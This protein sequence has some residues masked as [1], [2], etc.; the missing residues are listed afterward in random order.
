MRTHNSTKNQKNTKTHPQ[1]PS[2]IW[3][4]RRVKSRLFACINL[5]SRL[6]NNQRQ[7]APTVMS[8]HVEGLNRDPHSS[9]TP[10]RIRGQGKPGQVHRRLRRQPQPGE[11]RLQTCTPTEVGRPSYDPSD[12]LKLYVYGYL[13]QVRSSRKLERECHRNVEVMWLMKKL[14]P[15]FKTI[16][17]FRKDNIDCVKGVFK[18]FVK[19]CMSLDLYGAKCIAV[20]GTK[21]K[22]VNS[23]DSNFNRKNLA[24]RMKMIDE[25]VS[26]YLGEIEEEDRKEEQA[27]SKHADM[28]QEKVQKLMKRKEEYSELLCKLKESKQNEVSLVDPDC[29]LMK[30][31]GRI[32]PCYNGQVAVDDKNHL[33]VDYNVTNAPADNCQLSS[34]LK[35]RKRCLEQK[36]WM[37]LLTR[38]T[39]VLSKSKTALTT[40]LLLMCLSRTGM[41]L[42]LSRGRVFLRVE[43]SM[44]ISSFMIWERIRL[45]V[46]RAKGLFSYLDH[47]HQK[48]IR[49]YRT[50]ACFS[51]EFFMTKCTLIS[52]GG[53]CGVGSMLKCWMR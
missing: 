10:R 34:S 41:E 39:S 27:N 12:L 19:L 14:A 23:L 30:N 36:S 29:R 5:K 38:G 42:V 47:A 3:E 8:E 6:S 31:R 1:R 28:L 4:Q 40:E 53:R 45:F 48:N 50:D 16:A 51:C 11:T 26:K 17:D 43:N 52:M 44:L 2:E 32:E 21:F 9:Q 35:A 18:E 37:P 15:D 33:I 22:A 49:V 24:Y 13:N 46:R 7:G 20:D 25:H